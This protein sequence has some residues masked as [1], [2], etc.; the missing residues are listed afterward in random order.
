MLPSTSRRFDTYRAQFLLLLLLGTFF[1]LGSGTTSAN[2]SSQI[3]QLQNQQQ[4][5]KKQAQQ[6]KDEAAQAAKDAAQLKSQ[7]QV[8]AAN[9]SDKQDELA[10]T[11]NTIEEITKTI[12]DKQSAIEKTIAALAEQNR[13]KDEVLRNIYEQG[14]FDPTLAAITSK[15]VSDLV[16]QQQYFSALEDSVNLTIA[17][18]T[19]S[20]LKLTQEQTALE[21]QQVALDQ[22]K[23]QQQAAQTQ[24]AAAK[25]QTLAEQ[26][27]AIAD[28]KD[29]SQQAQELQ[30]QVVAIE[31]K[32][33]VLT[34][35]ARW[36]NDIISTSSSASWAYN[37]LN[38]S[39]RLGSSPFTVHDY[40]CL[41]TSI[42][43]LA[44]YY[45]NHTTPAEIASHNNFFDRNGDA[46]VSSIVDSLGLTVTQQGPINWTAVDQELDNNHPVIISVYLPQVGAL[47]SD[48]SSHFV[49][50]E[51]KSGN[52]Y[53]MEDPLGGGRGYGF[54]QVRSMKVL[55]PQ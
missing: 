16:D 20:Q 22:L 12:A 33:S 44:T 4:L 37:Q 26:A 53:I 52:Q 19:A 55:R 47:N 51:G 11:S 38:Y 45:G 25:A 35:T 17:D 36:G 15:S 40:G 34:A 7:A 43:M 48:G 46:Y 18:I 30:A 14:G 24:I 41:V 8:L 9:L 28:Q 32:L 50:V 21:E 39:N 27:S 10:T 13:N 1:L 2:T 42:A 31:S 6:K 49:V 3:Q 5:L 29:A 54:G 23:Q